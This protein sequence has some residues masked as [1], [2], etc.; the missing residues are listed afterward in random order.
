MTASFSTIEKPWPA[1]ANDI[2]DCSWARPGLPV[3]AVGIPGGGR[4][5]LLTSRPK[6]NFKESDFT[7]VDEPIPDPADGE[8]VVRNILISLDPTQR[9]WASEAPQYMPSIGL[10]TVMRAGTVGQ[11]V[12]SADPATR[13]G[14]YVSTNGGVQEYACLPA[15]WMLPVVADVPLSYNHSIFSNTMGFTAWLG[16]NI[17]EP[18]PGSTM[19]V[20]GAA[21]AVGSVAAQL[22]KARGARV[23]GL[24]G[25]ETKCNWLRNEAGLHGAINY[26]SEDVPARLR[27]LCPDGI[28]CYFD[29]VGGETLEEVFMQMNNFGR[30]TFCGAI[31]GYTDNKTQ[32]MTVKNYQMILMRRLRVQGFI[33]ADHAA[34]RSHALAELMARVAEG[35]IKFT[36]DLRQA[37]IEEYP[38]LINLLFSGGNRGKLMMRISSD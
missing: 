22:A 1:A 20:S 23:V 27:S 17:C 11:V 19:V 10:G 35:E 25:D 15:R 4:R 3:D 32:T 2:R 9:I 14:S 8:V 34:D 38:T 24:A 21:G 30:V 13:V 37:S 5:L 31:S 33:C 12:K 28:D 29:N 16:T 7:V 26:R 36:E 18:G 6:G